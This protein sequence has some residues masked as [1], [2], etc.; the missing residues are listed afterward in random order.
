M[1]PCCETVQGII[2]SGLEALSLS[3]KERMSMDEGTLSD[4]NQGESGAF[5]K[6][7]VMLL[8]ALFK[9]VERLHTSTRAVGDSEATDE[10]DV[11]REVSEMTATDANLTQ[12]T[13][14]AIASLAGHV[15]PDFLQKMF[16]KLMRRLLEEGQ[17]ED[18]DAGKLCSLL[19][20]AQALVASGALGESSVALLYR[21]MKPMTRND[22]HDSKVQKVSYK[23]LAEIC[24]CYHN[25]V[26]EAGTLK[27]LTD[28]LTGT[29][30]TSHISS[31]S[32]RLKCIGTLVDGFG[33]S[34]LTDVV[35]VS[36]FW[37]R[38]FCLFLWVAFPHS[39][40][41]SPI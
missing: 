11:E 37:P 40:N 41:S 29:A 22:G 31:R 24:R 20:L 16:K 7:S 19:N 26:S 3:V 36:C 38:H 33:E 2:C 8:P 10:M 25:V 1:D 13:T 14:R 21:T 23:V 17:N 30:I 34:D 32:M 4:E 18:A 6:A 9:N 12:Q 28:F 15:P 35:S 27:E 5:S 39:S